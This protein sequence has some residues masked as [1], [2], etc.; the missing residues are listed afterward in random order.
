[1]MMKMIWCFKLAGPGQRQDWPESNINDIL[2][3]CWDSSKKSNTLHFIWNSSS[4]VFLLPP[5]RQFYRHCFFPSQFWNLVRVLALWLEKVIISHLF[6]FQPFSFLRCHQTAVQKATAYLWG[7]SFPALLIGARVFLLESWSNS[8]RRF[9]NKIKVFIGT[10]SAAN[11]WYQ[12]SPI[13]FAISIVVRY[14]LPNNVTR[15][16]FSPNNYSLTKNKLFFLIKRRRL[17]RRAWQ[18]S[19]CVNQLHFHSSVILQSVQIP[20]ITWFRNSS[21]NSLENI[22]RNATCSRQRINVAFWLVILLQD[23][24]ESKQQQT[25]LYTEYMDQGRWKRKTKWLIFQLEIVRQHL[26]KFTSR[27]VNSHKKNERERKKNTVFPVPYV[28]MLEEQKNNL[29]DNRRN[30]VVY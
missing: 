10:G 22:S 17:D 8:S 14:F 5:F 1:M 21:R 6:L 9:I 16:S 12:T 27:G 24:D 26:T 20:S 25:A 4:H 23:I 3:S 30:R 19:V 28:L 11:P 2:K 7:T 29:K 15:I 13:H 18:S